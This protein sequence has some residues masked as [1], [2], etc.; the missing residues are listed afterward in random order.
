MAS[1][2]FVEHA[3][4]FFTHQ[5]DFVAVFGQ[6]HIGVVFPE[7]QAVFGA[8][9]EHAVGFV[10]AFG[11]EVVHQYAEIG[12]FAAQQERVLFADVLHGIRACEQA[13]C[14]GF[15]VAGRAV[16]LSGEEE[17]LDG[18]GFEAGFEVAR[19]EVVV[20]DG[21]AGAQD[22]G[23]FK[24]F[25][26]A[27]KRDLDVERQA[28]GDAVGVVF[29]GGQAFGFEENLVAVFVGEAVDFVFDRRAVARADAFDF[30]GKHGAAVETAADDVV[31]LQVGMRNPAGHLAR[32]HFGVAAHG[33]D[34]HGRVAG[35]FGELGEINRAAVDARRRAGFQTTLRQVQFAQTAA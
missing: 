26:A 16:D 7:L 2:F 27:H 22:M 19:V 31:G 9:G 6:A 23:V 24:A 12:L 28:G 14:G 18:F 3:P 4:L 32:V 17:A 35:L 15:F 34:G 1:R 13:L 30:A 25:H 29:V 20:F 8:A 11:D 5:A 21:V 33:E 10:H